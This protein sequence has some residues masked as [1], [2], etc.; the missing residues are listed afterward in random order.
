M[1]GGAPVASTTATLRV[2]APRVRVTASLLLGLWLADAVSA[3]PAPDP[4]VPRTLRVET[5]RIPG[6]VVGEGLLRPG[7]AARGA[8]LLRQDT[9]VPFVPTV[10]L[11]NVAG[12]TQVFIVTE[13]HVRARVIQTGSQEGGW[14]EI[15]DGARPGEIVA[16]SGLAQLY[17]GAAVAPAVPASAASP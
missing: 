5:V 17:D 7:L 4:T 8:V 13:G 12:T 15:L 1:N 10:A 9:G 11:L 14:V 3:Q 16:T 2:S 6:R